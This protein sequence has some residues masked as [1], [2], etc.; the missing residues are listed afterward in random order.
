MTKS[1]IKLKHFETENIKQNTFLNHTFF[2]IHNNYFRMT[3]YINSMY[4][5]MFINP[6]VHF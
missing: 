4:G 3:Y 6:S 1:E 5:Q 2:I